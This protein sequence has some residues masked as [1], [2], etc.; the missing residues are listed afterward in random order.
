MKKTARRLSQMAE[1]MQKIITEVDQEKRN[2][3]LNIIEEQLLNLKEWIK[4]LEKEAEQ[5]L[6]DVYRYEGPYGILEIDIKRRK[7]VRDELRR[8]EI[9]NDAKDSYLKHHNLYASIMEELFGEDITKIF[10]AI[11]KHEKW[12]GKPVERGFKAS[13]DEIELVVNEEGTFIKD[14][15][16]WIL[17]YAYAP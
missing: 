17:S 13:N 16:E 7:V 12:H 15:E 11:Y 4:L 5:E 14:K 10:P 1:V 2:Q 8:Q 9:W 3:S 6:K